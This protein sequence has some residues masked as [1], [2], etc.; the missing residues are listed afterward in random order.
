VAVH[1]VH[2]PELARHGRRAARRVAPR[3]REAA[4]SVRAV[5][6]RAPR[7]RDVLGQ[8][9]EPVAAAP[10]A[11]R[12]GEGV[13]APRAVRLPGRGDD[14][15]HARGRRAPRP[16]ERRARD[17]QTLEHGVGPVAPERQKVVELVGARRR[18]GAALAPPRPELAD[19]AEHARR[20][21]S[22][23]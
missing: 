13:V 6:E 2:A 22:D 17:A 10:G 14:A 1:E 19:L 15:E 12:E 9:G 21:L 7:G 5:A 23:R 11:A 3:R 4:G 16:R 8:V 20:H 18:R